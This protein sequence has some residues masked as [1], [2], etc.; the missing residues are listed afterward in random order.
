MVFASA[1][2]T[3]GRVAVGGSGGSVVVI[4]EGAVVWQG[5]AMPTSPY[6]LRWVDARRLVIVGVRGWIRV[7]DVDAGTLSPLVKFDHHLIDP[8]AL[9][10][11]V[12][13][14]LRN[15]RLVHLDV[16]TLK[17]TDLALTGA[18]GRGAPLRVGD[19]HVLVWTYEGDTRHTWNARFATAGWTVTPAP[20]IPPPLGDEVPI[21]GSRYARV[22][23]YFVFEIMRFS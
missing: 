15:Q 7:L 12:V 19:D 9:A 10:G 8:T 21:H 11:G 4:D 1:R 3:T 16:D 6:A 2:S 20:D 23:L 5:A 18:F 22:S 14:G 13:F 17:T